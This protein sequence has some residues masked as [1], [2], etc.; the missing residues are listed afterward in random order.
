[1]IFPESRQVLVE[2]ILATDVSSY[3]QLK[4]DAI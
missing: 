4:S 2:E 3:L 1:M